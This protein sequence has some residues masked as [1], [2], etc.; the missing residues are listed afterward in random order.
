MFRWLSTV[1]KQPLV[2]HIMPMMTVM[3]SVLNMG[4]ASRGISCTNVSSNLGNLWTG[5]N[6]SSAQAP[7]LATRD[8]FLFDR[9]RRKLRKSQRDSGWSLNHHMETL[10]FADHP[11]RR[12][13]TPR[14]I[15]LDLIQ[16]FPDR[17]CIT[18]LPQKM[19]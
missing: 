16:D 6:D 19:F 3:C 12:S 8:F 14:M 7:D 18:V 11:N 9:F 2:S 1:I 4:L 13:Y 10:P 15:E 5:E 17:S